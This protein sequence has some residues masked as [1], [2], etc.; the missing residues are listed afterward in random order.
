MTTKNDIRDRIKG[1]PVVHPLKVSTGDTDI[2]NW[3]SSQKIIFRISF[4]FLSMLAFP[5]MSEWWDRLLRLDWFHPNYRDI[6]DIARFLPEMPF[7]H[8][9]TKGLKSYD[10]WF[11]IFGIA[12]IGGTVWTLIDKK[13]KEYNRLYYW[14]RVIVRYRAGIGMVG[15]GMQKIFPVQM[16]YPP[17]SILNTALG[18]MTMQ[19][20]YWWEIGISPWYQVFTGFVEFTSGVLLFTRKTTFWG[21]ALLFTALGTVNYV[22]V[23]YD[24]NVHVYSTYFVVFAIF[25]LVYYAKDIYNLQ[26]RELYTRPVRYYP[27]FNSRGWKY[28]R[29]ILKALNIFIFLILLP[30]LQ[31]LNFIYDPYNQPSAKGVR[32]LRGYYNVTSFS[33]NHKNLSYSPL[34]SVRWQHVSFEKWSSLSFTINL[35]IPDNISG[36]VNDSSVKAFVNNNGFNFNSGAPVRDIDR[37]YEIYAAN[38][39]SFYYRAD[40]VN[41]VLYL[42]DKATEMKTGNELRLHSPDI[43]DRIYHDDW[44]PENAKRNMAGEI[45]AIPEKGRSTRRTRAYQK[46]VLLDKFRDRMVLHFESPDEGRKV[47]LRGLNEKGDSIQVVL[48]RVDKK[49]LLPKSDLEGGVY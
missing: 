15:F 7:V 33:I 37:T 11:V 9:F 24:G 4:I 23:A 38:Q 40:T 12:L 10:D 8:R 17:I 3:T 2:N 39:R 27:S 31:Y 19:K 13:R 29:Y 20:L 22:N 5:F 34:D 41:H 48:D 1:K 35:P 30:Y 36:R 42:Q 14:L 26:L 18:D 28:T 32:D 49:Y 47:I 46:N 45:Q 16:A 43:K 44:I 21:A 6:Y 25:L